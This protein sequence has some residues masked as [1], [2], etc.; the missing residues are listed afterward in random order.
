MRQFLGLLAISVAS[1]CITTSL[2]G[3]LT[4]D[5]MYAKNS[6]VF[7]SLDK[8]QACSLSRSNWY[9]QNESLFNLSAAE[10]ICSCKQTYAMNLRACEGKSDCLLGMTHGWACSFLGPV[11][12]AAINIGH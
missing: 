8:K 5:D 3:E 6:H 10:P 4:L 11:N 12:T 9:S 1:L 2:A 7:T